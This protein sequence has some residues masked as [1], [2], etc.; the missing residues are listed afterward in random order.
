MKKSRKS[1]DKMFRRIN[2]LSGEVVGTLDQGTAV[3]RLS[4]QIRGLVRER[5][6]VLVEIGKKVYVLH[7]AGKVRN[8]DV[9]SDCT[10]I[11]DLGE[12]IE[13]LRKEI[14]ALRQAGQEMKLD[15]EVDASQPLT[16]DPAPTAASASGHCAAAAA[17][18]AP[19]PEAPPASAEPQTPAADE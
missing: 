6:N 9:L 19:S 16:D 10:R 13:A 8:P 18:E 7:Q 4:Q 3:W 14:E 17:P 5:R 1:W 15:V 12:R 2:E 11:D